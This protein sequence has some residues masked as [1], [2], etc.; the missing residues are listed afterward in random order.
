MPYVNAHIFGERQAS[1]LLRRICASKSAMLL[2]LIH[3][4]G[5]K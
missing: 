1:N 2:L 4:D 5:D 3:A